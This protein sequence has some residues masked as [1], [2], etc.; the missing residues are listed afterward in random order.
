MLTMLVIVGM[1]GWWKPRVGFF[2][3]IFVAL[4]L[5]IH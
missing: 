4:A 1:I 2:L 5:L 3:L